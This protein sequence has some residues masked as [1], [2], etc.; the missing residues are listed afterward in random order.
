MNLGFSPF[1][2]EVKSQLTKFLSL[3]SRSYL[4]GET[5]VT[6]QQQQKQQQQQRQQQRQ[7]QKQQQQQQQQQR[8]RQQRQQ[9]RQRQ[10]QQQEEENPYFSSKKCQKIKIFALTFLFLRA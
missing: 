1:W 2:S 6:E 5:R 7:Q 10:Q 8:Q 3:S 4:S 9:Q